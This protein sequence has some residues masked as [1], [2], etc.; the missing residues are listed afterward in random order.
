MLPIAGVAA[1]VVGAA[2][3]V[4][5]QSRRHRLD[6]AA[7]ADRL[8]RAPASPAAAEIPELDSLPHPVA[9]YLRW[10][11]PVRAS[12]RAVRIHQAGA[13]RTDVRS[14]RWMP[15]VAEHVAAPAATAFV[16]NAR[17]A[18]APFLHV[19][20]RDALI[21]GRGSGRVRLLSAV[22]VAAADGSPE[23]HSGSLHRFLA[24][25]VW[26]PTALMPSARLRWSAIDTDRALATLTDHGASVSLEFRFA[27]TGEVTGVYTAA[28]WGAFGGGY[29]QHAWEGHFRNYQT[30]GGIRVPGE[31]DVG[32]YVDDEWRPVWRATV[33]SFEVRTDEG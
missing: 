6:V 32:W 2:L 8:M 4:W 31:G 26:Y 5:R 7:D 11:L 25:A 33:T 29:E 1:L 10:A 24:E 12:I 19:A 16:W 17:V 15:F 28:R 3:A 30:H 21:D 23:M 20:V 27:E 9:R 14:A 22:T 13:L 18:I